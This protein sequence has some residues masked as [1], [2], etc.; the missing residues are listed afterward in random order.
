MKRVLFLF[1]V[2]LF[3]V[4][5]V[6]NIFSQE[7]GIAP[8]KIFT[9]NSEIKNP[10]GFG[11]YVEQPIW[12]INIKLEYDYA[13]SERNYFGLLN[14]GFLIAPQDFIQDSINSNSSFRSFELSFSVPRLFEVFSNYFNIGGGI[15]LDNFSRD[16]IGLT[17]GRKITS[18][19]SKFGIFYSI[20]LSRLRILKLPIKLEILYKQ[21]ILASGRYA[22]DA[23]NPFADINSMQVIQINLGYIF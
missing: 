8:I 5:F 12:K 22:T 9:E 16:E 21:K 7:I 15:S 11:V 6:N 17:T 3:W 18:A 23:V 2:S 20:S 10:F 14:G 13:K 4:F 1:T 19:D